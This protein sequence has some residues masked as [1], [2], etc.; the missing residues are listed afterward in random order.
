MEFNL[1]LVLQI[2]G[3][4]LGLLYLWWEYQADKRMWLVGLV[5]PMV[6]MCLYF[7]KGLY[8]DFAINIYY[9]VIAI[10]GYVVWTF[11]LKRPKSQDTEQ[12]MIRHAPVGVIASCS[13]VLVGLWIILYLW[14]RYFTDSNVPV[15][16]AFTTAASIVGMWLLARKYIEQWICWIV[17]DAVC[18]GLY[19]YKQI[20][21]YALLYAIYTI[22]AVFGYF[23]WRRQ[24]STPG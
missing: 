8:A 23:K 14:L 9:L 24:A 4:A 5:M 10:Y 11:G 13:G 2:A 7:R 12:L 22:I 16:D 19:I 3:L 15:P 17:V 21:F 20:P 1:E 18:V 6:S